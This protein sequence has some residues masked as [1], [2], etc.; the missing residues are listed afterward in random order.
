MI[1]VLIASQY[2]VMILITHGVQRSLIGKYLQ[3]IKNFYETISHDQLRE[4]ERDISTW[5]KDFSP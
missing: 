1:Y 4:K 3:L 2:L 5:W